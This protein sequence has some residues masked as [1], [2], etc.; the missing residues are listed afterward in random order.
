GHVPRRPCPR[1]PGFLT[2]PIPAS[3]GAAPGAV[4]R[5][6]I[7]SRRRAC[8]PRRRPPD[9]TPLTHPRRGGFSGSVAWQFSSRPNLASP[10][11]RPPLAVSRQNAR[12][13]DESRLCRRPSRRRRR[14]PPPRA[15]G[16]VV[17]HHPGFE[18]RLHPHQVVIHLVLRV[19]T[20]Q[21]GHGVAE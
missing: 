21:R 20:E 15:D 14:L 9:A 3:A 1:P 10:P 16:R 7:R 17:G 13:L 4:A 19:R 18:E 5:P 12:P 11:A 6:E 2:L 8:R